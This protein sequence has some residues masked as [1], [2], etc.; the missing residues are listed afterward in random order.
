MELGGSCVENSSKRDEAVVEMRR[1][2]VE[3]AAE[4][5]AL[6]QARLVR[7][8]IH[9]CQSRSDERSWAAS[10]QRWGQS[11]SNRAP[12]RVCDASFAPPPPPFE[13]SVMAEHTER[14][15]RH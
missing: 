6:F 14:R 9:A 11:R 4:D 7:G 8:V 15:S 13:A 3:G 12:T 2:D 5:S 10:E 1:A